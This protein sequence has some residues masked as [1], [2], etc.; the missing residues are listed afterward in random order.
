M[1]SGSFRL[2]GCV[3]QG[4]VLSPILFILYLND[5]IGDLQK[6]GFGCRIGNRHLACIMFLMLICIII[7]CCFMRNK[8]M[9]MMMMMIMYADDLVLLSPSLIALQLMIDQCKMSCESLGL[10]LSANLQQCV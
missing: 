10:S 4:G 7:L 3:R 2:C 8:T 5:I 9:M 6:Q 1:L